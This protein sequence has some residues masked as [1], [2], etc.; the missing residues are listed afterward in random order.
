MMK[1]DHTNDGGGTQTIGPPA[2]QEWEWMR[3]HD[4]DTQDTR[5]EEGEV[6]WYGCC[7]E[8]MVLID[9]IL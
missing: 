8:A 7:K 4:D 9:T 3:P 1:Q 6:Q 5:Y 2:E